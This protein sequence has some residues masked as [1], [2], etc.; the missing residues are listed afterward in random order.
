MYLKSLELIGFKSFL[1]RTKLEFKQGMTAIVGP[2]GC[3]KSNISDS[4]RWV[5][6]EQSAKLLRGSKMEDCIFNGTENHKP[7]SMAEVSITMA[8][9]ENTIET[10]YNE[11][12]ITRRVF[13]SGEGQYFINK[14]PCR[15]KD[16][17]RIFMDTGIGTNSYSIMEQGRID[18]ILSSR[19]EDRRAIFEEASGIMKYKTDKREALRK[20]DQTEAN[21]L[22]LTDIIKEV[23]RQIISLQRQAGKAK[24]VKNFKE[25]LRSLDI[26]IS[27]EYIQSINVETKRLETQ[28]ASQKENIE[29]FQQNI[30]E[31][32]QKNDTLRKDLS[33]TEQRMVSGTQEKADLCSKLDRTRQSI[34]INQKRIKELQEF[35]QQDSND[36][37]KAKQDLEK[38]RL[39]FEQ[40]DNTLKAS[41]DKLASC[42]KDLS[43]KSHRHTQH[44]QACEKTK[45]TID[46]LHTQSMELE[47]RLSKTQ[48]KLHDMEVNDRGVVNQRER[49]AAEQSNTRRLLDGYEKRLNDF[50]DVLT[51]L[52]S[53]MTQSDTELSHHLQEHLKF[54]DS[55]KTLEQKQTD[56]LSNIA[57]LKAQLE[58]LNND[59]IENNQFSDAAK[60]LL[61]ESNPMEIDKNHILGSLVEQIDTTSEFKIALE[62]VL[63][64]WLDAIVITTMKD[65]LSVFRKLESHKQG[66]FRLLAVDA[67]GQVAEDRGQRTEVRENP[68]GIPLADHVSCP[69]QIRP[70][71]ER[72]LIHVQVVESLNDVP[73][74]LHPQ[75]IYVT[76]QGALIKGCGAIE[77]IQ[78]SFQTNNPLTRKHLIRKLNTSIAVFQED[79]K[80][81]HT[82]IA[83][84]TDSKN[85]YDDTIHQC[86]TNLKAKQQ[87]LARQE[88]EK[89]SIKRQ[90]DQMRENLKTITWELQ[91]LGKQ[92][93]SVDIRSSIINEMDAIRDQ[94]KQIKVTIDNHNIK[95]SK[96]Y[97]ELKLLQS[98]VMTTN[99]S[100]AKQKQT[101][102][103]LATQQKPMVERINELDVRSHDR[104]SRVIRYKADIEDLRKAIT[105]AEHSIPSTQENIR[106]NATV[107]ENIQK[108]R[109]YAQDEWK[110]GEDKL[111]TD[112]KS[113]ENL[114]SQ[115]N[116]SKGKCIEYRIKRQ[117]V[118]DRIT[119]E[120]RIPPD[121]IQMEPEPQWPDGKPDKE[122]LENKIGE[123]RVKI[124]AIGPVYEG[125]IEEYQ[126][127]E[128]RFAFLNQQQDDLVKAKQQLMEMIRKI[129]KTTT[130]LFTKTFATINTNFQSIFKQLFGGGTAKLMLA[131]E[132]DILESGIEII[133]RPPGKRLQSIPLLSG[134]E[135]TLTAVALLFAIYLF[136]P[137]PFCV[138]DELDA[139]LDETNI[140]RFIKV[141]QKFLERSQFLVVTHNR[142]T[143]S[144]ANI[145]YGIT[146]EES[147]VSK[148]VS[149]KFTD[150]PQTSPELKKKESPAVK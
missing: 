39:S 80:T 13:R 94:R 125:A 121:A 26:F 78:T 1:N 81:I 77:L 102:D 69:D 129:N 107:M 43:D 105:E 59:V 144:A 52:N 21:L 137:S 38:A 42:E 101:V 127:L 124:E 31:L 92:G 65:A 83:E 3:G 110:V 79:L 96:M 23:K 32:E 5:L 61:D 146:M 97:Q 54:S 133:A 19:P 49:T 149:M 41:N 88:G 15:L 50:S 29:T 139:A 6:G 20:L 18:L 109:E 128:E 40:T 51:N 135:R 44:E 104:S 62:A 142:Q 25:E 9:C 150:Q 7:L 57:A 66:A 82:E 35:I 58:L 86:R 113:L 2:N 148:I 131:D 47:D 8:D 75:A 71:I 118:M 45:L 123:L 130:E 117:N 63:R 24:R 11:I 17:Q 74:E 108:Q 147:G 95:L 141:L 48:N 134:G 89:Q 73:E 84:Q 90:T 100:F 91:E 33:E 28:M 55:I 145:L 34:D 140:V 10:E 98:E 132:D 120:Y 60:Q 114:Q 37:E 27:R 119:S 143:I 14:T 36:I 106:L 112:R 136:K 76:R 22:R 46:N 138:L 4:I 93:S 72:L 16:I 122:T 99:I 87:A 111:K 116:E 70:L 115:L 56:C 103:H 12:S 126:K 64:D 53:D 68:A 30:Q 85:S 67:G